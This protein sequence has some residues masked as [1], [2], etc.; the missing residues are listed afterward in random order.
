MPHFEC[1]R[2]TLAAEPRATTRRPR[3]AAGGA[4]VCR[5]HPS[6]VSIQT[7]SVLG[8]L[9]AMMGL[10]DGWRAIAQLARVAPAA[11]GWTRGSTLATPASNASVPGGR[12]P[13]ST[14]VC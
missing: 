6:G 1:V 4:T 13:W 8:I 2:H 14:P 11:P 5:R 3:G 10:P 9:G 7:D 12:A